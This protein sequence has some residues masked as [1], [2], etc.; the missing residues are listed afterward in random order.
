VAR[1]GSNIVKYRGQLGYMSNLEDYIQ[2]VPKV[3]TLIKEA[4]YIECL[5][6]EQ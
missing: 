5:D 1:Q 6:A 4:I 2:R 3:F